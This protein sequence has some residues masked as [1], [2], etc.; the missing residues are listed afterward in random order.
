MWLTARFDVRRARPRRTHCDRDAELGDDE[1][2]A[3][4]DEVRPAETFAT[5]RAS[6]RQSRNRHVAESGPALLFSMSR[7]IEHV[8]KPRITKERRKHPF[9]HRR[10]DWHRARR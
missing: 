5:D 7:G 9:G 1:R 8:Q 2:V 6:L 10:L 4:E 3:C